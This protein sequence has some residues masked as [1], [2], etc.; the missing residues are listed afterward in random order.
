MSVWK[1]TTYRDNAFQT[2]SRHVE[3]EV[4]HSPFVLGLLDF[5]VEEFGEFPVPLGLKPGNLK[6]QSERD[7]TLPY[8]IRAQTK[9]KAHKGFGNTIAKLK[10]PLFGVHGV[11]RFIGKVWPNLWEKTEK[12]TANL[13]RELLRFGVVGA[14]HSKGDVRLR[15]DAFVKVLENADLPARNFVR[16]LLFLKQRFRTAGIRADQSFAEVSGKELPFLDVVGIPSL[17]GWKFLSFRGILLFKDTLSFNV[18]VVTSADFEKIEKYILGAATAR[19][20]AGLYG[21]LNPDSRGDLVKATIAWQ[22]AAAD[23]MLGLT[24][25]EANVFCRAFDV[26]YFV[27]L[28]K[29]ASDV[30]SR[31]HDHQ[32]SKWH[33]EKLEQIIPLG[34]IFDCVSRLKPKEKLEVL[35]QYKLLPVADFDY[36]GMLYRQHELYKDRRKVANQ[37][38]LKPA[39]QDVLRYYKWMMVTGYF[40]RHGHCPGLCMPKG[41][42]KPWHGDYPHVDPSKISPDDVE[43]IDFFGAFKY[44]MRGSDYLDLVKDKA[45]CPPKVRELANSGDLNELPVKEKSQL[46]DM[47]CRNERLNTAELWRKFPQL[48]FD[49]K[50]DDKPEAKKPNGRMF[51]ELGS[52]ARLCISEYEDSIA[53]YARFIPGVTAGM[54]SG[55][56]V[57]TLNKCTSLLPDGFDDCSVFV[58]FDLEKWSP[59]FQA[60]AH[61]EIDKIWANAFGKPE[62]EEASRIFSVGKVHYLKGAIHHSFDKIGSEY[63]GHFARK[64]TVYHAAVMGM[65]VRKMRASGLLKRGGYFAAL[66]DDGLLKVALPKASV[67]RR[68]K[69]L[70]HDLEI[71]YNSAG[72]FISWDKTFVSIR[73]AIFLNEVRVDGRSITP[74]MKSVIKISNRSDAICPNLLADIDYAGQSTR[75]AIASGAT[76]YATYVVYLLNV[77]DAVRRW[78]KIK[79][80]SDLRFALKAFLPG[81]FGGMGVASLGQMAGSLAGDALI[82]ALGLLRVVG[83]RYPDLKD[84]I[85]GVLPTAVAP[86]SIKNQLT[87]PLAVK[88]TARGLRSDRGSIAIERHLLGTNVIPY[89]APYVIR[90]QEN[91]LSIDS[92]P[93]KIPSRFP[94]ELRHKLY[95]S[96]SYSMIANIVAKFQKS[97]SALVFVPYRALFRATLANKTEAVAYGRQFVRASF[98]DN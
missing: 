13:A 67:A 30:S 74:G 97:K 79:D 35:Q 75:G 34:K 7:H 66:L 12:L 41:Q 36:F 22:D 76:P 73:F 84:V 49:V 17:A 98:E 68:I 69:A 19:V 88:S 25:D 77:C 93:S 85:R 33:K 71:H 91:A 16:Q 39:F 28:A 24:K 53:D 15:E 65:T 59:T 72:Y 78:T 89:L 62:L 64:G 96:S 45:I 92:F 27:N 61:R 4:L 42:D 58:S 80:I 43:D 1:T 52:E 10:D 51:F 57:E 3:G 48:D 60:E 90:V 18:Y 82:E 8:R 11:Y 70:M 44:K 54:S 9:I 31:A 40:R 32:K 55:D 14:G 63:E 50:A 95:A 23:R 86:I 29:V 20:Y 21:M 2:I 83:I 94:F 26:A 6:E 47:M 5:E 81:R 56:L 37:F 87:N 46:V 38:W